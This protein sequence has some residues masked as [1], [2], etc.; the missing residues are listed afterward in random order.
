LYVLGSIT[1]I[2]RTCWNLPEINSTKWSKWTWHVNTCLLP[3]G[4]SFWSCIFSSLGWISITTHV[5]ELKNAIVI[6]AG[7]L[8]KSTTKG[9]SAYILPSNSIW[10]LAFVHPC[11][12]PHAPSVSPVQHKNNASSRLVDHLLLNTEAGCLKSILKWYDH[13]GSVVDLRERYCARKP[14][15]FTHNCYETTLYISTL[16]LSRSQCTNLLIVDEERPL[17]WTSGCG[18]CCH[19]IRRYS[20]CIMLLFQAPP[21]TEYT[22][23][24]LR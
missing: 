11:C 20:L 4:I 21:H 3:A 23:Y 24:T 19:L 17:A 22:P 5:S 15:T 9:F 7:V 1:C 8:I 13:K 16:T 2:I 10:P 14:S 6:K 18:I 12:Q